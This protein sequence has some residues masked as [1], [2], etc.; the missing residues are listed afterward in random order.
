MIISI[1][2]ILILVFIVILFGVNIYILRLYRHPDD[3]GWSNVLY[4]KV[5]VVL[6]LTLSQAQAFMVSLDVSNSS[7]PLSLDGIKMIDFWTFLYIIILLM[8][9]VF[10][11]FALFFYETDE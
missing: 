7:S 9:S 3:K 10:L 11:P 2:I 5:L 4:C 8:V 6:G 1:L